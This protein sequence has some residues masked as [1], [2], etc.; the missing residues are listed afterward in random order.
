MGIPSQQAKRE[1]VGSQQPL[2]LSDASALS[3]SSPSLRLPP[4]PDP[5]PSVK[6]EVMRHDGVEE[7]AEGGRTPAWAAQPFFKRE[8]QSYRSSVIWARI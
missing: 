4:Q 7:R 6:G 1:E 3:P 2:S 5:N 8:S